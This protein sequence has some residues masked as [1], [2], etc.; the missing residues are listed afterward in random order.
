MIVH[1]KVWT[2]VIMRLVG[3]IGIFKLSQKLCLPRPLWN[4][5]NK[6]NI[7]NVGNIENNSKL[8][9]MDHW[10]NENSWNYRNIWNIQM[11]SIDL[12]LTE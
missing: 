5:G 7:K 3:I 4:N 6:Q 11:V 9:R 8:K 10:N 1:L 12:P 2:I